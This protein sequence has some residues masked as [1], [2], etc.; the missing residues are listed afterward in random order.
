MNV[1]IRTVAA[2]LLSWEYLFR[3][4]GIMSLRLCFAALLRGAG[5]PDLRQG[6]QR[7]HLLPGVPGRHAPV[8]RTDAGRQD[9]VPLQGL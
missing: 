7:L 5:V 1:G 9:Q 4:F 6:R 8:R 3:I 2:Q